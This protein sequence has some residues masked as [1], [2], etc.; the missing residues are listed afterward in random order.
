MRKYIYAIIVLALSITACQKSDIIEDSMV[1]MRE[2]ILTASLNAETRTMLGD[3]DDEGYENLWSEGDK[4]GVFINGVGE[5]VIYELQDGAGTPKAT[6]SGIG[7]GSIYVA[8]YPAAAAKEINNDIIDLELPTEQTYAESSF[9]I[10]SFPMVAVSE[11]ENLTF[12]NLCAVLKISLIGNGSIQSI[13]FT[14]N[15]ESIF[16]AGKATV[17]ISN[18]DTPTL[19]MNSSE[20]NKVTLKCVGGGLLD[21]EN[22]SDFHIVLPAQIYEGGFT[23]TINSSNGT[24]VKSTTKNL[25][26]KRSEIVSVKA[27][28]FEVTEGVVPSISLLGEGTADS[29]FLIQSI[30]DLLLF[31]Q[32]VN[33]AGNI[34]SADSGN[35]VA[36]QTAYYLQTADID[37]TAYNN[38]NESWTPIGDYSTNSKFQFNGNYDGGNHSITNLIVKSE[39]NYSGLFGYCYNATIKGLNVSGDVN[40]TMYVAILAGYIRGI[41]SKCETYGSLT[42]TTQ[43]VG[44][45]TGFNSNGEITDC[46]NYAE[47]KGYSRTGGIV[48]NG[49]G[50]SVVNCANFGNI[51]YLVV[52]G[53]VSY[54]TG[55]IIGYASNT[56]IYNCSNSGKITGY[57]A[58]GIAGYTF[59]GT[60]YELTNC[61]NTGDLYLTPRTLGGIVGNNSISVSNC[62][63][64][65]KVAGTN[66]NFGG[67]AGSNN[68]TV[69][70]SYWLSGTGAT[71]GVITNNSVVEYVLPLT[72]EQMRNDISTG[73][74]LY[75]TEDGTYYTKLLDALNAWAADHNAPSGFYFGWE[76]GDMCPVFTFDEAVKPATGS[77]EELSH[78]F[79]VYHINSTFSVPQ[80]SGPLSNATVDWGDQNT[81][82]YDKSLIHTYSSF[83]EFAVTVTA[84]N[85]T[86]FKLINLKGVTKLELK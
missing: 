56:N 36:A 58:G 29:P 42:G 12:K 35:E 40:G 51:S 7:N 49:S 81:E 74:A 30:G 44:G 11:T 68:G 2:N 72:E 76:R 52:N 78:T 41:V 53:Y 75:T 23:L 4:I 19:V 3:L 85:V 63:S 10:N 66:T 79:V 83:G 16:V 59:G 65:A 21:K 84:E 62:L 43:Y 48:G 9:G 25:E 24:M 71:D 32:T 26:L 5:K 57:E 22:P 77:D 46:T 69:V 64:I 17:D 31:Q 20:E 39:T 38:T 27:F 13:T 61:Y 67:I 8:I 50:S 73:M 28:E 14:P 18:T 37:M 34:T 1:N 86:S 70:N 45:V 33:S 80:L 55:G 54:Y 15:N 60:Q 82:N 6:F 47:I